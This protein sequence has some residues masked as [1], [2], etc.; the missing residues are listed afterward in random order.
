MIPLRHI[1]NH[2]KLLL[3]HH[4]TVQQLKGQPLFLL[5]NCLKIPM[6]MRN[7]LVNN[8][9]IHNAFTSRNH[10]RRMARL[11][12]PLHLFK[13]SV[14]LSNCMFVIVLLIHLSSPYIQLMKQNSVL[15]QQHCRSSLISGCQAPFL[16]EFLPILVFSDQSNTVLICFNLC[17]SFLF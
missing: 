12:K 9:K 2:L 13:T 7:P 17:A 4:Q 3:T 8:L 10:V 14:E 1:K 15:S 5:T 11:C 16:A 6:V